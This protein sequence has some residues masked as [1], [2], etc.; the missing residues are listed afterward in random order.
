MY[1]NISMNNY[2]CAKNTNLKNSLFE[3]SRKSNYIWLCQPI[4]PTTQYVSMILPWIIV[5]MPKCA[6]Y[7]VSPIR[8]SHCWQQS[9]TDQFRKVGVSLFLEEMCHIREERQINDRLTHISLFRRHFLKATMTTFTRHQ[10]G[11]PR[12]MQD[13]LQCRL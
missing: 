8:C 13:L 11:E 3:H 6:F 1:Q 2:A 10:A 4:F 5:L 12:L 7:N 9:K